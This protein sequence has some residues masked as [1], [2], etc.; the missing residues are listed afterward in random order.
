LPATADG[1]ASPLRDNRFDVI[2]VKR[3][4]LTLYLDSYWRS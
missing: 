3:I 2:G 4:W 1:A